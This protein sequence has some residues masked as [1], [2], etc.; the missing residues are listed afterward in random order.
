MP[1]KRTEIGHL[2]RLLYLALGGLALVSLVGT[3][4]YDLLTD[5][6]YP[7]FDSFYMT[8]VTISTIGFG[9][10]IDMSNNIPAR[11]LTVS[12][13]ALGTGMLSM[14]FSIVTVIVLESDI[15]G[16]LRRKRMEK[17]IKKLRDHYI[18]CGIGRV[19]RNVASELIATDR[20]F[21]AIDANVQVLDEYKEKE[22]GLLFL[23]GDASDDDV[24]RQ[25]DLAHA[26]GL[27]AVTGDDS[28]NLMIVITAKQLRPE[29]RVVARC[30]EVRNIEKMKK[31]GADAIVSP[32]FTGGMR[33]ASAMLRPH[34]ASFMDEMLKTDGNFRIEEAL[35][36]EGFSPVALGKLDMRGSHCLPIAIRLAS[37]AWAFNPAQDVLVEAGCLLMV[38]ADA[39]GRR[40]LDACLR[41]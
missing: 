40:A 19:G 12:L 38:M 15:N 21:V 14:A 7:L 20:S 22:P 32:D 11:V 3:V 25:A 10:I 30:H 5:G 1:R 37:G 35:V 26:A 39:E 9:E 23:H 27:F 6:R 18:L 36:P 24:L 17:A 8:F 16:T 31:A 34:V 4:G 41:P 2:F 29:M 28:M 33:I 13:A